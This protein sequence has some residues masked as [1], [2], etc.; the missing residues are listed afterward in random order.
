[1]PLEVRG[2]ACESIVVLLDVKAFAIRAEELRELGRNPIKDMSGLGSQ[3]GLNGS[4]YGGND[5]LVQRIQRSSL[6]SSCGTCRPKVQVR[7]GSLPRVLVCV[8]GGG[9]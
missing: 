4:K 9:W 7:G 2:G 1:M 3:T 8:V 6:M 5:R